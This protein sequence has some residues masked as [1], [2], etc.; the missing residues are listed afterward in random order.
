MYA[1]IRHLRLTAALVL[2]AGC[3]GASPAPSPGTLL[4]LS[5]TW[6][7]TVGAGSGGGRA[8][9]VTWV[10]TETG[11]T[12]SGAATFSTSP[13]VTNISFN[14]TLTGMLTG[15][16]LTLTYS[17]PPG[18]VPTSAECFVSGRGAAD[19]S[20]S[21]MSGSLDVS[22]VSC[23]SLGL[24]PPLSNKLTLTRQ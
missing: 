15:S 17:A 16:Q 11:S 22:F 12:V 23:D 18:S 3:G 19:V 2:L 7:G 9:R 24:E 8:L 13:A 4:D 1:P 20:N 5:G 14:G 21:A 6:S 10:A